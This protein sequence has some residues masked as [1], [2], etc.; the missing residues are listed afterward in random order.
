[1]N[2]KLVSILAGFFLLITSSTQ[3]QSYL[4]VDADVGS[5]ANLG[6]T[7]RIDRT[8]NTGPKATIE[9]AVLAAPEATSTIIYLLS[10]SYYA[11]NSTLIDTNGIPGGNDTDGIL[12]SGDKNIILITTHPATTTIPFELEIDLVPGRSV[13]I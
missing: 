3:A 10:R 13:V 11:D 8:A 9:G 7:S 2:S 4:Y 6:L 1:M 5:D 12:F